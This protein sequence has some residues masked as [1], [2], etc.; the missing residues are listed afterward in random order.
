MERMSHVQFPSIT[1]YSIAESGQPD[2]GAL[3]QAAEWLTTA[4]LPLA[5]VSN[6]GRNTGTVEPLVQLAGSL[7]MR[8]ISSG[9]YMNFPFNHPCW[10]D[11]THMRLISKA[12]ALLIIDNDVPYLPHLI[13]PRPEAKVIYIDIDAVKATMPLWHF[14]ASM[15][16]QADSS[17]AIPALLEEVKKLSNSSVQ[18]TAKK[19]LDQFRKESEDLRNQW[20]N[21]AISKA[22]QTPISLEYLCYHLGKELEEDDI[23]ISEVISGFGNALRY[24]RRTKPGTFFR[25]QQGLNLGFGMGA[26]IGAKLAAPDKFVALAEADGCFIFANP[27]ASLWT[28]KVHK[29]PFLAVIFNNEMYNA[30]RRDFKNLCGDSTYL[31][32]AAKE[33]G[34]N[35]LGLSLAPSPD[36]AMIAQANGAKGIKVEDPE[37]LPQALR[38]GVE[39]V[40][41]GEMV[42]LDVKIG[43]E[44]AEK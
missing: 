19:R 41:S 33:Q 5:L 16:V 23:L 6:T 42:L 43:Q 28:A 2:A 44:W 35:W 32:K 12:D 11:R 29:A 7:G 40:K 18:A 34:G 38:Q 31:E 20:D 22:K 3:Q 27:T 39:L 37:K 14:P 13:R 1:E 26:A 9:N 21:F 24:Y 25:C 10:G 30:P 15:R 17:K 36:Y 8:V 4:Q